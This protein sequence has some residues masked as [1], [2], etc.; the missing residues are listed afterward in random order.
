MFVS[1]ATEKA[2]KQKVAIFLNVAG[3]EA[4]DVYNSLQLS[5]EEQT[6]YETVLQKFEEYC[7][8]QKNET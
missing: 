5:Q 4:L 8:P 2:D 3:P 1:R 6:S 7:G